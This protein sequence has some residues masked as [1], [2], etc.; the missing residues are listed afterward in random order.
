MNVVIMVTGSDRYND[1]TYIGI[2]F[3]IEKTKQFVIQ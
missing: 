1:T 2:N 3:K